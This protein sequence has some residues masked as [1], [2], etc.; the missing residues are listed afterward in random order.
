MYHKL[1]YVYGCI[2]S[3]LDIM[4]HRLSYV[5]RGALPF[6][7]LVL[8]ICRPRH[9]K[10]NQSFNQFYSPSPQLWGRFYHLQLVV[11]PCIYMCAMDYSM[12]SRN[13]VIDALFYL[14]GL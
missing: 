5:S 11:F 14:F 1:S 10:I 13:G 8:Y 2:F 3:R 7:S 9:N 6:K 4:Y 12:C